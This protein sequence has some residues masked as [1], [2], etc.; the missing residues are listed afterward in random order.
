MS[1]AI[2]RSAARAGAALALLLGTAAISSGPVAAQEP[3]PA[4]VVSYFNP[5]TG[6]PTENPDVEANS[7]CGDEAGES[8][9]QDD[10]QAVVTDPM[11]DN[12]HT[13]G[14]I[15]DDGGARID[16]QAAFEVSGVGT[17]F[18]C[19]DPDGMDEPGMEVDDKTAT[20]SNGD[21]L[22]VLSGYED[23]NDEYH[24]RTVSDVAG[25]Q[26]V[27]MCA[28]P[29]GNGCADADF[30]SVTTVTW[31]ADGVDPGGVDPGDVPQGG[32]QTG[33]APVGGTDDDRAPGLLA[34]GAALVLAAAAVASYR[35]SRWT[36]S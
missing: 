7:G 18:A 27:T 2:R 3:A 21:T 15:F 31:T 5:D 36:R 10:S 11:T 4:D 14:C 24:V 16:V 32:V 25:T 26:T 23:A 33:L 34:L 8:P 28:D 20:L 13:D 30:T 19:P 29:E 9:D 35:W 22:C 1:S 12:V 17:I 6:K